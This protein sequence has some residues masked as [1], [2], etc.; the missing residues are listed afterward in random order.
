M[1]GFFR[2]SGKTGPGILP[3]QAAVTGFRLQLCHA[4]RKLEQAHSWGTGI[5]ETSFIRAI[6]VI[7]LISRKWDCF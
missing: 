2:C 7:P 4:S 5:R 3:V 6:R 1:T